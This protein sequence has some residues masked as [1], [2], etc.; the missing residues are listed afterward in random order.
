[1]NDMALKR[2]DVFTTTPFAGNPAGVV[3]HA[4]DLD[5]RTMQSLAAQMRMNLIETAFV[6]GSRNAGTDFR[7][8]LAVAAEAPAATPA[9]EILEPAGQDPGGP[10]NTK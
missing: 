3:L 1:M 7:G 2:V 4:E 9:V 8:V 5:G 10:S 6:S